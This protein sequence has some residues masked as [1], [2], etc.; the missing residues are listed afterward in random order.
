MK[1]KKGSK[2]N[3]LKRAIKRKKETPHQ[4]GKLHEKQKKIEYPTGCRLP[5]GWEKESTKTIK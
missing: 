3:G 1:N 5:C 2:K 4:R